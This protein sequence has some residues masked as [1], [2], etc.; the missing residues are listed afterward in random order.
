MAL[1]PVSG[2]TPAWAA[3]PDDGGVYA[4]VLRGAVDDGAH[5]PGA[6]QDDRRAAPQRTHVE[7]TSAHQP[8]LFAHGEDDLHR[9]HGLSARAGG[10]ERFENGGDAGLVI[11]AQY[12]RAVAADHAGI[13][14][15]PDAAARLHGVEVGAEDDW[16]GRGSAGQPANDVVLGVGRHRAA[17]VAQTL[18][19]DSANRRL[20]TGGAINTG[21]G[22]ERLDESLFV[23]CA[24]RLSVSHRVSPVDSRAIIAAAGR[25]SP[26]GPLSTMM[27]RGSAAEAAASLTRRRSF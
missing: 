12:R 3:L 13:Q 6:V 1:I 10:L 8:D 5:R 19:H 11:G 20:L 16:L 15:R 25:T 4:V 24:R 22:A 27:E 21:E 23:D 14:P 7:G 9:T 18:G 17:Q 26:P 2:A